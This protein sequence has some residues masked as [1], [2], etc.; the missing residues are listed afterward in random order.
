MGSRDTKLH[1]SR[2]SYDYH[3]LTPELRYQLSVSLSKLPIN[4]ATSKK[5]FP[6]S[7]EKF[8]T[9]TCDSKPY[10][11]RSTI[12]SP[13]SPLFRYRPESR[14]TS[15]EGAAPRKEEQPLE[16]Q[17]TYLAVPTF[18]PQVFLPYHLARIPAQHSTQHTGRRRA[19]DKISGYD[20]CMEGTTKK[21]SSKISYVVSPTHRACNTRIAPVDRYDYYFEM[22][23]A[24]RLKFQKPLWL[25]ICLNPEKPPLKKNYSCVRNGGDDGR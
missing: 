10:P 1:E 14:S 3:Q 24:N 23:A 4:L 22:N 17:K 12:R 8:K 25:L 20:I 2:K 7:T 11:H 13:L 15:D 9:L 5:R 16:R 18:D 19:A 6:S 21:E